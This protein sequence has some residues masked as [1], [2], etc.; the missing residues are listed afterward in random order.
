R[1]PPPGR[2]P[3]PFGP[4]PPAAP[5]RPPRP[6]QPGHLTPDADLAVASHGPDPARRWHLA[7]EGLCAMRRNR[8]E[9]PAAGLRVAQHQL[10][11]LGQ[12]APL[13]GV[14]IRAMVTTAARRKD[15]QVGELADAVQER[16]R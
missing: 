4:L 16:H 10:I 11:D 15:V 1:L 7:R 12:P 8:D 14:S 13:D 3:P 6:A 9:Q 5:A 2:A